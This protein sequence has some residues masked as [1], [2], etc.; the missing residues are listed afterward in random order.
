MEYPPTFG[1]L[2]VSDSFRIREGR[3]YLQT[4]FYLGFAKRMMKLKRKKR[5]NKERL[6][7]VKV[8]TN[9]LF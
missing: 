1:E 8:P 5:A 7:K 2:L 9:S 3:K 6:N 4:F